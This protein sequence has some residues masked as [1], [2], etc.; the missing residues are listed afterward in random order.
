MSIDDRIFII[1]DA[2]LSNDDGIFLID[3]ARPVSHHAFPLIGRAPVVGDQAARV[4]R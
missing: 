1:S 3:H 2:L 4:H